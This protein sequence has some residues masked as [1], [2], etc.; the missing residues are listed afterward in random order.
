[1]P[2]NNP[3]Q[4]NQYPGIRFYVE[5]P[6]MAIGRAIKRTLVISVVFLSLTALLIFW[7]TSLIKKETATLAL[8]EKQIQ[9]TLEEQ[10]L[11]PNLEKTYNEIAPKADKIKAA[12]PGASDLLGYQAALEEAAKNSQVTIAVI[13]SSQAK[14]ANLPGQKKAA[15]SGIEHTA[16]IKGKI[17][18]IIEFVRALENLPYYSQITSFKISSP[19]DQGKDSSATLTLKV[20]TG[21]E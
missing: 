20:F 3:N 4:L 13:F 5:D 14:T 18:N 17:E 16:E 21:E 7:A 6:A 12:L 10:S 2:V 9:A 8:E 1:M 11:D 19:Q 15:Y